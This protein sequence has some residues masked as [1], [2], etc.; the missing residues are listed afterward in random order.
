[1]HSIGVGKGACRNTELLPKTEHACG[2]ESRSSAGTLVHSAEVVVW[3]EVGLGAQGE[4][5]LYCPKIVL[6]LWYACDLLW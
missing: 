2:P 6:G 5:V 1:M 4:W 3:W